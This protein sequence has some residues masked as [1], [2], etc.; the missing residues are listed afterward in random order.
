[1]QETQDAIPIAVTIAN[2]DH[3]TAMLGEETHHEVSTGDSLNDSKSM[4][5]LISRHGDRSSAIHKTEDTK[6]S[7]SST[8]AATVDGL[9]VSRGDSNGAEH[10]ADN[11]SEVHSDFDSDDDDGHDSIAS[12][13]S[14]DIAHEVAAV[15]L[16]VN[17]SLLTPTNETRSLSHFDAFIDGNLISRSGDGFV[18]HRLHH[19]T[20]TMNSPLNRPARDSD[21]GADNKHG[22]QSTLKE[23]SLNH[24]WRFAEKSRIGGVAADLSFSCDPSKALQRV[25]Q[26]DAE[27][28]MVLSAYSGWMR[29]FNRLALIRI[30]QPTTAKA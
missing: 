5:N 18:A 1:M 13:D 12:A 29:L 14:D 30:C 15:V 19:R 23:S 4:R 26:L 16:P 25:H 17:S 3:E 10:E 28:G 24:M 7:P 21:N 9:F 8:T 6:V 27:R 11:I 22:T 20:A 2:V